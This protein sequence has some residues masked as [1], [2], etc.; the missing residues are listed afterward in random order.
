MVEKCS[1]HSGLFLKLIIGILSFQSFLV[2]VWFYFD[3]I[4]LAEHNKYLI[5]IHEQ[6]GLK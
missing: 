5:V 4:G 2:Y 6:S 3:N 1:E